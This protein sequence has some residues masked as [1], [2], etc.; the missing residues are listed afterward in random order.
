[1][2]VIII[3]ICIHQTLTDTNSR[4]VGR[5]FHFFCG[6]PFARKLDLQ[7]KEGFSKREPFKLYIKRLNRISSPRTHIYPRM[8]EQTKAASSSIQMKNG[9]GY[10]FLARLG[11]EILVVTGSTLRMG[12]FYM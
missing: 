3:L 4:V 12:S 2:L 10:Q 1:M 7:S 5:S 8:L 11:S 6:I 9:N